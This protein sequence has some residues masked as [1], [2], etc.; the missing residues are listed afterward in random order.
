MKKNAFEKQVKRRITAR[1]HSFFAVCPPGL[2]RVCASELLDLGLEEQTLEISQGG[3]EFACKPDQCMNLHLKTGTIS[4]ILMRI[5]TFKADTF[6]AFESKMNRIEWPLFLPRGCAPSFKVTTKKSALYHSDAIAQRSERI[7][8]GQL[9]PQSLERTE[10]LPPQTVHIRAVNNEFT[11]SLDC[12]G[13][14]LYKRGIKTKVNPAPLRETLAFAMLRWT[15]FK[16]E[17]I[18][19]DPMCGS[20]TFSLEGAMIK[21]NIPPGYFRNFAFET[22]PGFSSQTFSWQKKQAG[23]NIRSDFEFP[24]YA[25]DIDGKAVDA[26]TQNSRRPEIQGMIHASVQDFFTLDTAFL[27]TRSK[28]V[29]I[30]NPPYGK[31][32]GSIQQ[33]AAFYSE[34]GKKL[35]S[36]FPGWRLGI[37]IPDQSIYKALGI[38]LNLNRIF[39]GGLDLFAGIGVV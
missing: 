26:L 14:P 21:K 39:H 12:S 4:R 28:G 3:I 9:E 34:I 22:W 37:I 17:D 13:E 31:R 10:D 7:I 38:K 25:F 5:D 27:N 6:K 15:G 36:D 20:G 33:T 19:I 11:I 24:I 8:A 18:L 32:L 30:L 1:E 23:E 35:R 16:K 29:I 2:T